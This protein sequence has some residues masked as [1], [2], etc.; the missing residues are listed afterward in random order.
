MPVVPGSPTFSLDGRWLAYVVTPQTADGSPSQLWV[1]RADGAGAHEV[2]KLAVDWLVGWSPTADQLAVIAVFNVDLV[3][4]ADAGEVQ[5]AAAIA[6]DLIISGNR[7]PLGLRRRRARL[8]G[9]TT[10]C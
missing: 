5:R 2:A 1:A 3:R 8:W 6:A 10:S 4:L 7:H 9:S